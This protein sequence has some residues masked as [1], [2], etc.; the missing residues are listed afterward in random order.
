MASPGALAALHEALRAE[1]ER[2][3]RARGQELTGD[4]ES[5]YRKLDEMAE[6][7]R[8]APGLYRAGRGPEGADA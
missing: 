4:R 1:Q 2:R 7:L 3:T 5:F 6:R 8:A